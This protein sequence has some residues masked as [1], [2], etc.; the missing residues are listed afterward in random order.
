MIQLL[1]Y[2]PYEGILCRYSGKTLNAK[3]YVQGIL[4]D[5]ATWGVQSEQMCIL[6]AAGWLWQDAMEQPA[7]ED[8]AKRRAGKFAAGECYEISQRC[9]V[10]R[11]A[12]FDHCQNGDMKE[13]NQ[14]IS[15]VH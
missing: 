4:P 9:V 3:L 15:I 10:P 11:I 6:G 12:R 7:E 13:S 5:P 1:I 8:R 14:I 2:I